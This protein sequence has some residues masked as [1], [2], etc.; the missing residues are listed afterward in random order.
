MRTTTT[1]MILGAA[2]LLGCLPAAAGEGLHLELD[3]SR[4][5]A[6]QGLRLE[7][8]GVEARIDWD[9]RDPPAWP[10][11]GRGSLRVIHDADSP[12]VRALL[13]L[14]TILDGTRSFRLEVDLVIETL[15]APPSE[16]HQLG[17]GLSN[18]ATTGWN[19]TGT[20]PFFGDADVFDH[21]EASY[22]PN[23]TPW[24]GPTLTPTVFGSTTGAGDAFSNFAALFGPAA[25]LG[26]NGPGQL[27][28]LA[29]GV[30]YRLGLEFDPCTAQVRLDVADL[31]TGTPVALDTGLVPL[32]VGGVL[33]AG[34]FEVDAV[35]L[36]AF[37]DLADWDPSGPALYAVVRFHR[38]ALEASVFSARLTPRAWN[39]GRGGDL[40]VHVKGAAGPVS[41][42]LPGASL[43]AQP[44]DRKGN[45]WRVDGA[46]FEAA[47][48]GTAGTGGRVDVVVRSGCLEAAYSIGWQD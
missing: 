21:I 7:G 24:G 5:P 33:A 27:R 45:V 9:R 22:F 31:S 41:I 12:G 43:A 36:T 32:E 46:A 18:T 19:R 11:D 40:V 30:P 34:P 16:F 23:V 47:V 6:G 14:G 38:V 39:R 44:V 29:V 26:D 8:P 13:P 3:F 25:D 10:G 15:V 20:P 28:E 17:F 35:T 4:D 48:S 2:L 37:Q 42:E 1:T